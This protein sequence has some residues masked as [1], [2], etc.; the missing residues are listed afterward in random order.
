MRLP[1]LLEHLIALVREN[2]VRDAR[3]LLAGAVADVTRPLETLEQ[4]R[5]ARGREQH[6]LR[7]VDALQRTLWSAC[8]RGEHIE[9]V[10]REP[11]RGQELRVELPRHGRVRAQEVDP[12][13]E[14]YA[15]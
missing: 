15:F 10:D 6:S 9:V 13:L 4:A 14:L 11:V 1:R 8:K 12:G 2:R 5:D 7:E 3:V